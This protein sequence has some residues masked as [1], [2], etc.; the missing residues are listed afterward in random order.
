MV[1]EYG[2]E[3]ADILQFMEN[4]VQQEI[5]S[6]P[7]HFLNDFLDIHVHEKLIYNYKKC[8]VFAWFKYALEFLGLHLPCKL[9]IIVLYCV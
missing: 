7:V 8:K 1:R 9:N 2:S 4:T 3:T 6:L 5:V